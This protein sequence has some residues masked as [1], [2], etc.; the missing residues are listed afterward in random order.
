MYVRPALATR[1]AMLFDAMAAEGVP[2]SRQ[3]DTLR[4]L[5]EELGE[6]LRRGF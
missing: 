6:S 3:G 1:L 4:F 2:C 5:L